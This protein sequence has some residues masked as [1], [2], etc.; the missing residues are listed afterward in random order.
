MDAS[1]EQRPKPP[2]R[3]DIVDLSHG[4]DEY[5]YDLLGEYRTLDEAIKVARKL[6]EKSIQECG[7]KEDWEDLGIG[8][9]VY[10]SRGILVWDGV[11]EYR[12]ESR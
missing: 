6:T 11:R 4:Q 5:G 9:S 10:D 2:F 7:S 12:R 1:S 8:G 3:V